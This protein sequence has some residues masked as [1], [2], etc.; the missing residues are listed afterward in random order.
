[1]QDMHTQDASVR[2]CFFM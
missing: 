2:L 1:M